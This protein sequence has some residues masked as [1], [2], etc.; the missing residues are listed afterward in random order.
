[1]HVHCYF[2]TTIKATAEHCTKRAAF[3]IVEVRE[4]QLLDEARIMTLKLNQQAAAILEVQEALNK[5]LDICNL[6]CS[7]V[8]LFSRLACLL[9]ICVNCCLQTHGYIVASVLFYR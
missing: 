6:F 9:Y 5:V 7:V 1:M 8:S 3:H 4:A 2:L